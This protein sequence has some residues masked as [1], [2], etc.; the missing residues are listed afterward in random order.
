MNEQIKQKRKQG[1]SM[2]FNLEEGK[3]LIDSLPEGTL[4]TRVKAQ[5]DSEIENY[6]INPEL[7]TQMWNDMD[8]VDELIGEYYDE[9]YSSEKLMGEELL[10]AV[11][12][13]QGSR[14]KYFNYQSEWYE[15]QDEERARK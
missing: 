9:A 5:Y 11:K 7:Y 2:W 15:K 13:A 12:D 14:I 6:D 3:A 10:A 1:F 4:K 8:Y